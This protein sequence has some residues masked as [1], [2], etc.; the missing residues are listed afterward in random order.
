[1]S[2]TIFYVD[3]NPKMFKMGVRL[4]KLVVGKDKFSI[5]K[6]ETHYGFKKLITDKG[7]YLN[8]IS[9]VV[10][11]VLGLHIIRA[12]FSGGAEIGRV[13]LFVSVVIAFFITIY[14]VLN[15]F[16]KKEG[17]TKSLRIKDMVDIK[18]KDITSVSTRKLGTGDLV[19]DLVHKKGK[20]S[21]FVGNK[22]NSINPETM[23]LYKLLKKKV[24]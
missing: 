2:E 10:V 17:E 21:F 4:R 13:L 7:L 19:I 18:F 6:S 11:F 24:S 5:E 14:L 8:I 16:K 12:F 22:Y 1:M 3:T 20:L 23:R 9:T 15:R